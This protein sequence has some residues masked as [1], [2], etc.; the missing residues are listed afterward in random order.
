MANS[1]SFI[2]LTSG[3]ARSFQLEKCG[4]NEI[5]MLAYFFVSIAHC[6][7]GQVVDDVLCL[8]FKLALVQQ[9]DIVPWGLLTLAWVQKKEIY[10]S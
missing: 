6:L 3:H 1:C 4:K 9:N 10:I 2:H 7:A 8:F 5:I